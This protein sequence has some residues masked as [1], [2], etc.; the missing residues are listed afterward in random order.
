MRNMDKWEKID[1]WEKMDQY[2]Q[3]LTKYKTTVPELIY[4]WAMS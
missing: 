4:F 2:E 1:E 3:I